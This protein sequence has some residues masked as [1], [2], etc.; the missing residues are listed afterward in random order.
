MLWQADYTGPLSR[1]QGAVYALTEVDTVTGLLF[2][3]PGVAAD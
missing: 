2:A 1:A 3:W